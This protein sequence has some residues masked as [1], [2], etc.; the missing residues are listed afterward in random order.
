MC[1]SVLTNLCALARK[2]SVLHQKIVIICATHIGVSLGVLDLK[3]SVLQQNLVII[4]ASRAGSKL[5]DLASKISVSS[6]Q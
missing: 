2:F 3:V 6:Y 1:Y 4:Q 5:I